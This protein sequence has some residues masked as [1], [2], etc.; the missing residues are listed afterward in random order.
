M[1]IS[2]TALVMT[3]SL[4]WGLAMAIVGIANS[5][6]PAYGGPLI[7]ALSSV[8][9]GYEGSGAVLDVVLGIA[10]GLIDGALAGWV[11]ASVYNFFLRRTGG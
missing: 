1:K 11:I 8:Y 4:L 5:M 2:A 7:E 10:Y 6:N 3:L 9:P